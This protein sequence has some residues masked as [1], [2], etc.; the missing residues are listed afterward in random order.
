M[1]SLLRLFTCTIIV[2]ITFEGAARVDD[3]L[4]HDAPLTG[5][6]RIESIYEAKGETLHGRPGARF[7]KWR[8]NS[9]G[10]R[11]PESGKPA[12]A[13]LGSSETFGLY[14]RE[15]HEWPRALERV[16]AQQRIPNG[17]VSV[18]NGA[19]PGMNLR[20]YRLQLP[21]L[22]G[23]MGARSII[24]Y[25]ALANYIREDMIRT[26]RPPTLPSGWE[27]RIPGKFRDL[28]KNLLP[29]FLMT[30]LRELSI[31][32]Q[33][34]AEGFQ[35]TAR[36]SENNA[37]LFRQD[38]DAL[39]DDI[40]ARGAG[41]VLV[42]HATYFRNIVT[43]EARPM[44]TAWRRFY[45]M[46]AEEGFLDM[47]QRLNDQIRDAARRRGLPLVDVA[48]DMPGGPQYFAD[49]VHFTDTGAEV[50]AK[51]VAPAV[52]Q[53]LEAKPHASAPAQ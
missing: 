45:P 28:G 23:Q 44:L 19:Y 36:I 50:M 40:S 3:W 6:H 18:I 30:P 27:W 52:A 42:T 8:L 35:V 17:A 21:Q 26:V 47:E 5:R 22:I 53:S 25:P 38:L 7:E 9:F 46:L 4:R 13:C 32:Q 51:L 16:L 1:I 41:A 24:L 39:L 2:A 29:E 11:G 43:P 12:V 20:T 31:K 37:T 14:E 34:G 33:L 49:F 48:R 15:N 10:Y